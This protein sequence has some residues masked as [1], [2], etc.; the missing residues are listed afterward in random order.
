MVNEKK[1]AGYQIGA[2]R[3]I[4]FITVLFTLFTSLAAV[5]GY[6]SAVS[7]FDL[8]MDARAL[9]MGGAFVGLADDRSSLQCNP[10][11]LAWGHALTLL[12]SYETRPSTG[13][14]GSIALLM[15][16]V[17][18]GI[19]YFD[20]GDIPKADEYGNVIDTF[21][22]RNYALV[23]GAGV[24]AADLPLL[25]RVPLAENIGF[26]LSV[27]FLNV[28]TLEPG[29]G[30]GFAI[31]IPLLFR[32]ESPSPRVPI[33]TSYGFGLV[34]KNIIGLPIKYEGEHQENWP[35]EIVIGTAFE[36]LDRVIMAADL[37]SK[38]DFHLGLEWN[39]ISY[40]SLRGGV[41]YDGLWVCS[42]GMGARFHNFVFDF[43][44]VPHPY[45][46]SEFRGSLGVRW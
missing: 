21:R 31:D 15:P 14:Y 34:F 6:A 25:S 40:I 46:T 19:D 44:V 26:G 12:S 16:Y 18:F 24:R 10:A 13:S 3:R 9:A 5:G 45:L 4:V 43:A 1:H 32:S 22:Y 17:G 2:A 20:F 36:F 30:S 35:K 7:L 38:K 37:T 41:K 28:S 33:I 8:G 11:G 39:P 29:S 42:F 23:A 27:K